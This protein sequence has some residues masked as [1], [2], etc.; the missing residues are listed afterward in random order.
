M[1]WTEVPKTRTVGGDLGL[2]LGSIEERMPVN[3]QYR[4]QRVGTWA[5][6][7]T[8]GLNS[9]LRQVYSQGKG[10]AVFV[11]PSYC[12]VVPEP[13]GITLMSLAADVP[14]SWRGMS[15][16]LYLRQQAR[17]WNDQPT[18]ALD[19][20][21]AYTNGTLAT[22]ERKTEAPYT[23]PLQMTEFMGYALTL[24][25][26]ASNNEQL[27]GFVGYFS[28]YTIRTLNHVSSVY[29]TSKSMQHLNTI[30]SSVDGDPICDW[31]RKFY[32][33]GWA[34]EVLSKFRGSLIA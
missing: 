17:Y 27:T 13:P 29:D 8:H 30:R 9:R 18:Y 31:A 11:C 5:H 10:N 7:T 23:D 24:A 19:E 26:L 2:Y 4:D 20:W 15:Y 34:Q 3:H 28:R 6:E 16:D 32:G 25:F 21:T 22:N 33:A 1:K 14:Q 12:C